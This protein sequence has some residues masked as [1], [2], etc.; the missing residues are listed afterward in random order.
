MPLCCSHTCFDCR[1][2]HGPRVWVGDLELAMPTAAFGKTSHHL[3]LAQQQGRKLQDAGQL[4]CANS[5]QMHT[6]MTTCLSCLGLCTAV[7][8]LVSLVTFWKHV[9]AVRRLQQHVRG[10]KAKLT[11]ALEQQVSTAVYYSY[12]NHKQL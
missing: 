4:V 3:L 2:E 9:Q 8:V 11:A 12:F 6:A 1:E 10:L 7:A 5:M